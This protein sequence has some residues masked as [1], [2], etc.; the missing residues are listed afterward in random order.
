MKTIMI[1]VALFV[2]AFACHA[3]SDVTGVLRGSTENLTILLT[4]STGTFDALSTCAISILLDNAVKVNY[5]VMENMGRGAY[6]YAWSVPDQS[7]T[8]WMAVNCSTPSK[9]NYTAGGSMLVVDRLLE[10]SVARGVVLNSPG[11][12]EQYGVASGTTA[13]ILSTGWFDVSLGAGVLIII[14]I[15]LYNAYKKR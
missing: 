5:A 6:S 8:Y 10:K 12:I 13:P 9:E 7:G 4:N 14:V 15:L 2:L 3:D 1:F 11:F